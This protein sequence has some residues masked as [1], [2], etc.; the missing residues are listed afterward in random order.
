MVWQNGPK[1]ESVKKT[2]INE[3]FNLNYLNSPNMKILPKIFQGRRER[4]ERRRRERRRR[5]GRLRR[6]EDFRRGILERRT[7][8]G[9]GWREKRRDR[10]K[11]DVSRG[12]GK[13]RRRERKEGE[14]GR[15]YR[16]C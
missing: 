15:N 16:G 7:R 12:G 10:N 8:R 1:F 13:V 2:G 4:R 5:E 11:E 14:E 3:N 9:W 6:G